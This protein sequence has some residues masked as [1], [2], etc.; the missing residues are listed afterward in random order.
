MKLLLSLIVGLFTLIGSIVIFI[1]GILV[2][3]VV[4]KF[5]VDRLFDINADL[6][7]IFA[8]LF[9]AVIVKNLLF[10]SNE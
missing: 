6:I 3:S 2:P 10:T 1:L 9:A 5:G 4:I 8:L 7:G